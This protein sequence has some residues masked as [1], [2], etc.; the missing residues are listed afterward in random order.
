MKIMLKR[1]TITGSTLRIRNTLFKNKILQK[2]KK[3]VFPLLENRKIKCFI[4][5]RYKLN[6]VINAH[7]RLY[8]GKHIGKVILKM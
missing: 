1:L 7:K 3:F 6:D 8:E 4:D 5:S 2:L